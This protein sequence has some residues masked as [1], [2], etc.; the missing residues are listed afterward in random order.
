[1]QMNH[2]EII[3][4]FHL[5]FLV[6]SLMLCIFIYLMEKLFSDRKNILVILRH[7]Y[8]SHQNKFNPHL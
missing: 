3:V 4:A 6:M 8:I 2:Q 5:C 1:M 7:K